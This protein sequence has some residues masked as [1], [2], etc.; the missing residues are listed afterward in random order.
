MRRSLMTITALAMCSSAA[1]AQSGVTHRHESSAAPHAAP[2]SSG[3]NVPADPSHAVHEAMGHDMTANPHMRMTPRR[4]ASAAD[5]ARAAKLVTDARSSLARYK[6]VRL[7]ERDGYR[8]FAPNVKQDVYHYTK[9][10]A[11]IR[12]QFSLDV[13]RPSSFLY[14]KTGDGSMQLV[15][16]MYSAPRNASLEELNERVPLGIARWHL[17][18]NM[19]VPRLAQAERWKEIDD[20][21][22]VF[23]PASPIATREACDAVD[24]RFLPVVF[25]WMVHANV[26]ESDV[27]GDHH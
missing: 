14:R 16:A 7:A 13:A 11:A 5:S 20:G 15:G 21:K 23:G 3:A 9:L 12:E 2:R 25:N 1:A 10:G 6:D 22:M 4:V 24:G 26:F 18:T 19:C 27:W 8:L 17:H